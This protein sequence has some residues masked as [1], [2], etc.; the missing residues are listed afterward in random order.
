[1]R[2]TSLKTLLRPS[3]TKIVLTFVLLTLSSY[4]WR[5]YIIS[6]VSDTFPW[7]FPLQFYLGW[8]PCP[9]GE[10]C[11]ESNI[12]YLIIDILFW[13]IVSGFLIFG[14]KLNTGSNEG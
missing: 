9:P 11:I 1:M 12:L 4:L 10:M 2:S 14:R 8:G 5:F 6:T 13:Y 7:G 3:L